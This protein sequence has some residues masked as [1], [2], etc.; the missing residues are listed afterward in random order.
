[1]FNK[2]AIDSFRFEG[3]KNETMICDTY[4]ELTKFL[5]QYEEFFLKCHYIVIERQLPQNYKATR[6]A[7]HSISY[8]SILLQDNAL[9]TAIVEIDPK[10]KGKMLGAPKGISS[11]Q[12][13]SWAIEKAR[14]LLTAREDISSLKV[15]DQFY[16]KQDDLSDT[17][18]QIEALFACWGL[19]LTIMKD[20]NGLPIEIVSTTQF[21]ACLETAPSLPIVVKAKPVRAPRVQK[22]A[23]STTP[24]TKVT[25]RKPRAVAGTKVGAS[26]G[27]SAPKE[28]KAVPAPGTKVVKD[29]T[30]RVPRAPRAPKGG[31]KQVNTVAASEIIAV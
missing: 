31:R 16:R 8:F 17:V 25:T 19:P 5:R 3:L 27:A 26:V 6:I 9:L 10:L 14:E 4:Q 15:L 11:T 2:V 29:K 20:E 7:Q 12:L 1:V 23:P 18:C 21:N 30:P 22:A 13:K 28:T 24:G